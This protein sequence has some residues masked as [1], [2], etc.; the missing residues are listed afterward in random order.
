MAQIVRTVHPKLIATD[1]DV[2]SVVPTPAKTNPAPQPAQFE[3]KLAIVEAPSPYEVELKTIDAAPALVEIREAIVAAEK[4]VTMIQAWIA[5][6][7]SEEQAARGA[8][9]AALAESYPTA[10]DVAKGATGLRNAHEVKAQKAALLKEHLRAHEA[11]LAE[12]RAAFANGRAAAIKRFAIDAEAA[13]AQEIDAAH[14]E[15]KDAVLR[16]WIATPEEFRDH[17]APAVS[18]DIYA[19]YHAAIAEADEKKALLREISRLHNVSTAA[20]PRL[21]S[22]PI[23]RLNAKGIITLALLDGLIPVGR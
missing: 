10:A 13:L 2:S 3:P 7:D 5:E 23:Q 22:D 4:S 16:S 14:S 19:S 11:L 6:A 12:R 9:I 17:N 8:L 20:L 21:D 1:A 15:F 18:S